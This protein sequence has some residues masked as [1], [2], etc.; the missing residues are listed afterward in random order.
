RAIKAS[1]TDEKVSMGS[2]PGIIMTRPMSYL[3]LPVLNR[4]VSALRNP[5]IELSESTCLKIIEEEHFG[6]IYDEIPDR[7]RYSIQPKS[8]CVYVTLA[9]GDDPQK[10]LRE[11][12][13]L[14]RFTLNFMCEKGPLIFVC[15][16]HAEKRRKL[17]VLEVFDIPAG[18]ERQDLA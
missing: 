7:Y 2:S 11:A 3:L 14:V 6:A 1:E 13:I 15:G 10:R 16:M 8:K 12:S 18:T 17:R 5:V 4:R 9:D